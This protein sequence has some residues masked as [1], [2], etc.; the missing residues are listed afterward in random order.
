MLPRGCRL[1]RGLVAAS[2][3]AD[4]RGALNSPRCQPTNRRGLA[5]VEAALDARESQMAEGWG[6]LSA[7][8]AALKAGD[9]D[10]MDLSGA[11]R[12]QCS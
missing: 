5:S 2:C 4:V 12:W 8:A 1:L 11:V 10:A 6:Q 3:H 9:L 7:N